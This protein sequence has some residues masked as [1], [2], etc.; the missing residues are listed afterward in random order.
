MRHF[1]CLPEALT[2]PL[3]LSRPVDLIR[4]PS[5]PGP[6]I[7]GPLALSQPVDLI[8]LSVHLPLT[9]LVHRLPGQIQ[10]VA[11]GGP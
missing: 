3:A 6:H 7:T 4:P 1:V 11:L 8:R 2:L 5:S 9:L 10:V